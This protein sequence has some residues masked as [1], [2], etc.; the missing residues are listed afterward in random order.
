MIEVKNLSKYYGSITAIND[1]SFNISQ[2]D[3]IGF[4]GPNGAG[5]TTTMK[6]LTCFMRPT[7]GSVKI[8]G[9]DI[10][11]APIE[12][13]KLIGY[14]PESN[15][16]YYDMKVINYLKYI[17]KLKELSDKDLNKQIDSVIDKCGLEEVFNRKIG[18]LSKGYKQ[19]V[20]L[21]QA[22][23]SDP[24]ILILDE[25]TSGLDPNQIIEIRE[26]IKDLGKEKTVILSTH[27]LPEVE[28]TCNRIIIINNGRLVADGTKEELSRA[29]E[30]V[31][32]FILS[33]KYSDEEKVKNV[34][35][36]IEE[37]KHIKLMNKV[38]N[39]LTFEI[40]TGQIKDINEKIFFK[41]VEN[42]FI[43][44]EFKKVEYSLED[45]FKNLT[46]Q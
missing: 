15:P 43:I 22:I 25:P 6:I 37:I 32:N 41:C 2:G 36:K 19:R 5:K 9:Y 33:V 27:I 14:L 44:Y 3:I 38:K 39:I 8:G 29:K 23:I 42:N 17:G 7:K 1:I 35:D 28:T 34:L 31:Y 26:L 16:L 46:L 21:A 24:P 4:L 30:D 12:V 45:I 40:E 13:K 18:N 11:D 20:G 10:Y